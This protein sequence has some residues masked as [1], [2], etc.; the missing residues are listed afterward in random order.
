MMKR[1]LLCMLLLAGMAWA[2]CIPAE[3]AVVKTRMAVA[4]NGTAVQAVRYRRGGRR[5]VVGPRRM[6]RRGWY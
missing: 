6:T 2:E 1:G 4:P 3:A 5:V